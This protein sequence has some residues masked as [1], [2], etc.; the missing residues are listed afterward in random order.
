MS[1]ARVAQPLWRTHAQRIVAR[2]GPA[3]ATPVKATLTLRQLVPV[4]ARVRAAEAELVEVHRIELGWLLRCAARLRLASDPDGERLLALLEELPLELPAWREALLDALRCAAADGLRCPRSLAE[5]IARCAGN[6]P[7]A[8]AP[9]ADLARAS[10]RMDPCAEGRLVLGLALLA[11]GRA[12]QAASLLASEL[13]DPQRRASRG[14]R[15]RWL[16]A[17][18]ICEEAACPGAGRALDE[19]LQPGAEE[20][21]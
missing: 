3:L 12:D 10:L 2:A 1:A 11:E 6:A 9:A 8:W 13:L 5:T 7:R 15:A 20:P 19:L 16:H 4:C 14:L 18:A 17:L 21:Q